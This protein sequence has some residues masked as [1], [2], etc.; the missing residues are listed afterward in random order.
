MWFKM[1]K[2]QETPY[3]NGKSSCDMSFNSSQTCI[4][5]EADNLVRKKCL[6]HL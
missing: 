3:D 4:E 6:S 2:I 5:F 1:G